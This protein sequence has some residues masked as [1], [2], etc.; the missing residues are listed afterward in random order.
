[1]PNRKVRVFRFLIWAL[2]MCIACL[3]TADFQ[4]HIVVFIPGFFLV[5]F[6]PMVLIPMHNKRQGEQPDHTIRNESH[7]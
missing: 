3:I 7:V 1:M 6:V 5:L 4:P 2:L